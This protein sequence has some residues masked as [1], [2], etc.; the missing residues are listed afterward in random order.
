VQVAPIE[1]GAIERRH[2]FTGTLEPA[3]S[4]VV[5]S[6]VAGRVE[7]VSVEL[8]DRVTRGQVVVR[9]DDD[10]LAQDAAQARASL[11]VAKAESTAAASALTISKGAYERT[12]QLLKEG[13]ATGIDLDNARAEFLKA[14]AEAE[15]S[16]SEVKRASAA[17]NAAHLRAGYTSV[18]A[19]WA[20]DD[21][22][23]V[24][25][26]R[27]VDEGQNVAAN[28]QLLTVVDLDPV[29]VVIHATEKEYAELQPGKAVS[30]ATDAFPG[31]SFEARV[32]RVAPTFKSDSRQARVELEA[33]N[34]DGRLKPGM[35]VRAEVILERVEG[36]FIVPED[37]LVARGGKT[38][39]FVV[40]DDGTRALLRPV[41]TGIRHA[42]R[43]AIEADG[44]TSRVV[45]LGQGELDDGALITIP[46]RTASPTPSTEPQEDPT[47]GAP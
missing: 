2:L 10:E 44:L 36:T 24:V 30:I 25:A 33:P 8:G 34:S 46:K 19:E 42:G 26:E 6:K 3:A 40:S 16:Q 38:A 20:G 31:V 15:V 13:I 12:E 47:E 9:L 45:T 37:A 23:R 14:E 32:A 28:A 21:E 27:F 18:K 22:S 5:T 11:A 17:L 29:K 1:R 35:F 39:I 41:T 7:K 4:F 43:V